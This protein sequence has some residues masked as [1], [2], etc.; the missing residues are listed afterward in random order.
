M[1]TAPFHG[2]GFEPEVGQPWRYVTA[3]RAKHHRGGPGPGKCPD[4]AQHRARHPGGD[5]GIDRLHPLHERRNDLGPA[6][7]I[8]TPHD[9][10]SIGRHS[11]LPEC[12]RAQPSPDI[13]TR[14]PSGTITEQPQAQPGE[15]GSR[16]A[17]QPEDLPVFQRE[18]RRVQLVVDT[19]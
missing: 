8:G 6:T 13:D 14:H 9:D 7:H 5:L 2:Q 15:A 10:R 16:K 11:D 18:L 4:T 3:H 19:G 1:G 12:R 17:D